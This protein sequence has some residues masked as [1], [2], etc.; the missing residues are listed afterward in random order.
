MATGEIQTLRH[1]IRDIV[2]D[3]EVYNGLAGKPGLSFEEQRAELNG[4]AP[5]V[6]EQ[7][8]A[9]RA[10]A[11]E[12]EAKQGEIQGAVEQALSII[13]SREAD[14]NFKA[15]PAEE[16]IEDDDDFE[17]EEFEPYDEGEPSLT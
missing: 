2:A 9:L 11:D 7:V 12:L 8:V 5:R 17:D 10:K 4:I 6:G 16:E 3:S 15:A 14:P 1:K 13:A